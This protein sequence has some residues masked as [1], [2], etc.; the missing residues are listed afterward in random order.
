MPRYDIAIWKMKI[1]DENRLYWNR[2]STRLFW[3]A[4][5][6]TENCLSIAEK[7]LNEGCN[8]NKHAQCHSY[9]YVKNQTSLMTNE[10]YQIRHVI[11]WYFLQVQFGQ[12][13]I[14]IIITNCES[15]VWLEQKWLHRITK[16]PPLCIDACSLCLLNFIKQMT[17]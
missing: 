9:M 5:S 11:I 16:T 4:S 1:F 17:E 7:H 12:T 3:V 14:T 6:K 8:E 10:R 13:I 15:G 2:T